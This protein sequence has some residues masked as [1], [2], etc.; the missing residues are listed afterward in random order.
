[1][2]TSVIARGIGLGLLIAAPAGAQLGDYNALPGP[3]GV[4]AIRNA[5][6]YPVSGPVI[7]RKSVV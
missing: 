6:I 5:K 7:D 2:H 3:H 4:Y 1:M